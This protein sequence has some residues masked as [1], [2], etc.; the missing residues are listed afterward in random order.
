MCLFFLRFFIGKFQ[1]D[2]KSIRESRAASCIVS[3][4]GTFRNAFYVG[5]AS[6]PWNTQEPFDSLSTVELPRL[7][8]S[9]HTAAVARRG[10]RTTLRFYINNYQKLSSLEERKFFCLFLSN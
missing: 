7:G 6:Q 3:K 5:E 2:T 4:E 10:K 1:P 9:F 8:Q